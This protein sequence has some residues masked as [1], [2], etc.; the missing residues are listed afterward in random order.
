[1]YLG[2][3]LEPATPSVL[4][5]LLELPVDTLLP[6]EFEIPVGEWSFGGE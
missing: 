1:M 4:D 3:P 2:P 6:L 5:W